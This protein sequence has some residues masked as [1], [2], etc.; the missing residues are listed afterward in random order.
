MNSRSANGIDESP[1]ARGTEPAR[2]HA[3]E[4]IGDRR[5]HQDGEPRPQRWQQHECHRERNA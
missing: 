3:V 2:Q 1:Q 4:K 5:Q